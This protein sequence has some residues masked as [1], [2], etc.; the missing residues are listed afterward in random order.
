MKK[1]AIL[2]LAFVVPGFAA[3]AADEAPE[4]DAYTVL[5]CVPS[6][7]LELRLDEQYIIDV[8]RSGTQLKL[9]MRIKE[10]DDERPGYFDVASV[11]P[12]DRL[13]TTLRSSTTSVTLSVAKRGQKNAAGEGVFYAVF[14]GGVDY[15]IY[16]MWCTKKAP[17][18]PKPKPPAPAP[19]EPA[20]PADP[21]G[22][23][24]EVLSVPR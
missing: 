24:T 18:P 12:R 4:V 7:D 3:L 21:P 1:L 23:N 10:F 6:Q 14:R 22:K 16:E 15:G 11:N 5:A 13:F 19:E 17:P 20:E 2:I 9:V 8:V